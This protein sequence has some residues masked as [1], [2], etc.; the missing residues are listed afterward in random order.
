MPVNMG[1]GCL[2]LSD[3][4]TLDRQQPGVASMGYI[5]LI[6]H[7]LLELSPDQQ[8]EVLRFVQAVAGQPLARGADSER[9]DEILKGSWGA[10]GQAAVSVIDA[11]L[12]AVRDEWSGDALWQSP[13]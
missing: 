9:L 7:K 4:G 3:A 12:M 11:E 2:D 5:D 8:A 6:A 1:L 10:W 13:T